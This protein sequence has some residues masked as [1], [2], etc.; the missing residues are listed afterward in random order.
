MRKHIS[1][2]TTGWT[3]VQ[4]SCSCRL[5]RHRSQ[6]HSLQTWYYH[7]N[8]TSPGSGGVWHA[9]GA[10]RCWG[11]EMTQATWGHVASREVVREDIRGLRNVLRPSAAVPCPPVGFP[12]GLGG[13]MLSDVFCR[14][15]GGWTRG[16]S[17][18]I[19]VERFA[20]RAAFKMSTWTNGSN[21]KTGLKEIGWNTLNKAIMF[22]II[23]A[24]KL[25]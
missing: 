12:G 14:V 2:R 25:I 13:Q 15:R 10:S 1:E 17:G 22:H 5:R 20:L 9:P 8:I 21:R 3:S 24:F 18:K 7:F 4:M 19:K 23:A 11:L 16:W 6:S